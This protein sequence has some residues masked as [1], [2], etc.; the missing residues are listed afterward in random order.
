MYKIV[1]RMA[2]SW[3][4][5]ASSSLPVTENLKVGS[6][7][8]H[9]MHICFRTTWVFLGTRAENSH[10]L[11]LPGVQLVSYLGSTCVTVTANCV[12]IIVLQQTQN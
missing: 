4:Y 10:T 12:G 1:D 2:R 7:E 11:F 3:N 8:Y 6:R 5:I 9:V